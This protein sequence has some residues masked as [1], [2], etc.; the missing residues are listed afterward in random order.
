MDEP[1]SEIVCRSLRLVDEA[2]RELMSFSIG[3]SGPQFMMRS[4]RGSHSV[5]VSVHD[6]GASLSIIGKGKSRID[7]QV[8]PAGSFVY[9][10][11]AVDGHAVGL[12]GG[13]EAP[14]VVL[15]W[16]G[17]RQVIVTANE[18][19]SASVSIWKH[20]VMVDCFPAD[21]SPELG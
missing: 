19:G 12:A 14:G 17:K 11:D 2:G 10:G 1:Q 13:R 4:R 20:G 9:V 3:E 5:I 18:D 15:Y 6:D 16:N 7:I 8:D 21:H